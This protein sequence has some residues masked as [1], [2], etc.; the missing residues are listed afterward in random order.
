MQVLSLEW[1]PRFYI[2][3]KPP[4]S[5]LLGSQTTVWTSRHWSSQ[6][7]RA[8]SF[9]PPFMHSALL[10]STSRCGLCGRWE[11]LLALVGNGQEQVGPGAPHGSFSSESKRRV[12]SVRHQFPPAISQPEGSWSEELLTF[13]SRSNSPPHAHSRAPQS[14]CYW[15]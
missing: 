7:P 9:S 6:S 1:N 3:N 10:S 4:R 14:V 2:S 12:G 15:G 11:S 8:E 13:T 5:M